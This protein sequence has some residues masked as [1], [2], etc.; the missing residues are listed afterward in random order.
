MLNLDESVLL[1]VTAVD[2]NLLLKL[3]ELRGRFF[4]YYILNEFNAK[5]NN[6]MQN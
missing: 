6:S 4:S 3:T 1:K 2:A 5:L